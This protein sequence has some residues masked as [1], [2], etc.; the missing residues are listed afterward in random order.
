MRI[1]TWNCARGPWAEKRKVAEGLR[2]D[3]LVLTETPRQAE[4]DGL[5]WF[6]NPLERNGTTVL[7]SP[8]YRIEPMPQA[9]GASQCVRAVRVLGPQTFTLLTVWTWK[10]PPHK[11]YKDPFL[12]GL[13]AYRQLDGPFVIAGDFNGNVRF[14]KPKTRVKWRDCFARIEEFGVVSA[15]HTDRR[16]LP[17]AESTPT[18]YQ[19]RKKHHPFHIDYVFVPNE[20]RESVRR[21]EVPGFDEFASSDHRPVIVDLDF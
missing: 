18:Q 15:Y 11:N 17:G 2:A 3:V 9:V 1:A 12:A 16:E 19:L 13:R 21:V 4:R 20:W 5:P 7:T 8:A 10:D 6:G 14:D